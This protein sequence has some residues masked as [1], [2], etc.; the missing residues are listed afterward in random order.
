VVSGLWSLA[1]LEAAVVC[2]YCT[3]GVERAV[4]FWAS[5]WWEVQGDLVDL[6]GSRWNMSRGDMDGITGRGAVVLCK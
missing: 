6:L 5:T 1:F 3:L 4:N 2:Q